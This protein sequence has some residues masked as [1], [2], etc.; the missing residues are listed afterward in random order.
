MIGIDE[1]GRGCLAGPLLVVAARQF[2]DLPDGLADSKLLTRLQREVIFK[3]LTSG[4]QFGEGWVSAVEINA[5][6]L[7]GAMRLGVRRALR[8]L[9][10]AADDEIIMDGPFNYLPKTFKRVQ[11]LIDADALVPLVSAASVYAKVKRDNFMIA[12]ARRHPHYGFDNHVGYATAEHLAALR[13]HGA[14]KKVHR[15]FFEPVA[16]L[17]NLELWPE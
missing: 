12:L 7:T 17:N 14:L 4:V 13:S 16:I 6:G 2:G 10:P 11:C 3:R 15:L 1:V 8:Q 5:R 9:Q